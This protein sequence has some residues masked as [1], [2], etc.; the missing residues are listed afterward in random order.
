MEC[1]ATLAG[2][3]VPT[4][5]R[6]GHGTHRRL[7]RGQVGTPVDGAY[8]PVDHGWRVPALQPGA[9]P[10]DVLSLFCNHG[11]GRRHRHVA[12]D[13]D[14]AQPLVPPQT[15]SGYGDFHGGVL[16]RGR[17]GAAYPWMD[18]RPRC[19]W[20][21]PM[22]RSGGHHRGVYNHRRCPYLAFD[23]QQAGGVRTASRRGH[24]TGATSR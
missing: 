13:D 22:E 16:Y 1:R 15:L 23:T 18:H 21:R 24:R 7:P 9:E 17:R 20:P 12:S 3:V 5:G 19:P 6:L 8:R 11:N 10:L 14:G 4:G 2:M